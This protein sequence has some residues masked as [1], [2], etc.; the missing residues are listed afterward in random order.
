MDKATDPSL[1]VNDGS[2][3]E[4][5]KQLQQETKKK[6]EVLDKSGSGSSTSITSTPKTVISKTTIEFKANSSKRALQAPSSGKLAFSLKQ[7]SKLVAP[8]V[9]FGEDE[10]E[11]DKDAGNSSDDGPMKR[12]K[13]GQH[14]ASAQ[15][16]KQVDVGNYFFVHLLY[17]CPLQMKAGLCKSVVYSTGRSFSGSC[18]QCTWWSFQL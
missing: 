16:S 17:I 10:D 4:R 1:F 2:F 6:G 13:L 8:P 18:S 3:L 12:P 7:K 15:S 11:D 14:D 9:K 5:F